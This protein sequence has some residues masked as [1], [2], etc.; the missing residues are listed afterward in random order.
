MQKRLFMFIIIIFSVILPVVRINLNAR[1]RE[2]NWKR[3]LELFSSYADLPS[4]ENGERLLAALPTDHFDEEVGDRGD[5]LDRILQQEDSDI[6]YEEVIWGER[7]AI[8]IYIRLLYVADGANV[9]YIESTIGWLAGDKPEILLEELTKY[10]EFEPFRKNGY[11]VSFVGAR[12]S[13]HPKAAQYILNRR[14]RAIGSVKNPN[15]KE[16]QASCIKELR[17]AL[18]DYRAKS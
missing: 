6:L 2:L 18:A 8:E 11:P 12:Y 10:A 4:P 5:A 14:I 15:Y 1:D 7:S 3:V 9:E 16:V 13:A 17:Q